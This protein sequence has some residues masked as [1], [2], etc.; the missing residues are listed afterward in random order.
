MKRA[1][2]PYSEG[3]LV[4]LAEEGDANHLRNACSLFLSIFVFFSTVSNA[5]KNCL[6][7]L[8]HRSAYHQHQLR[9]KTKSATTKAERAC[10][11]RLEGNPGLLK[12]RV[13]SSDNE[14]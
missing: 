10:S 11:E 13:C 7:L 2:L 12:K 9:N 3:R 4:L 5:G 8:C 1:Q 14:S 6:V